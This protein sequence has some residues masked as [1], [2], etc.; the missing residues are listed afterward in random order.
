MKSLSYRAR[1]LINFSLIFICF[2]LILLG[3]QYYREIESRKALLEARL[4]SYADII[5]L[6]NQHEPIVQASKTLQQLRAVFPQDLRITIISKEG[7]VNYESNKEDLPNISN[8][9]ERPEVKDALNKGFGIDIRE[10]ETL[11]KPYFYYAKA[12]PNFI[13]RVAL[14]YNAEI[15]NFM[16]VSNIFL[17]F[18]L[19]IFPIVIVALIYISGR[20]GRAIAGLHHF[21]DSA[22]R[23]LMDYDNIS[24]PHNELGD[25][26]SK[27]LKMYQELEQ[28]TQQVGLERERLMKHFHHFE[29]GIAIFSTQ[30]QKVYSNPRFLQYLNTI[31]DITTSSV[32]AIW[33]DEK[34]KS[35]Q[36][37][38]NQQQNQNIWNAETSAYRDTLSVGSSHFAVQVVVYSDRSFEIT[39]S[40][41][42]KTEKNKL[43]KQQMSHNIS[44]ELR[45]PVSSIRGF[46]ETLITCENLSVERRKDFLQ[47]ALLQVV[48]LS[49]LIRDVALIS[50]I[51]EAAATLPRE[52][53][54]LK[55][56]VGE[57]IEELQS[58]LDKQEM[59]VLVDISENTTIYGNYSLLHSIFRNLLENS[60]RYAGQKTKVEISCYKKNADFLFFRYFNNG[61]Q[62]PEEHLPRLFE[63]FYRI[64]EGRTRD[65]GGTGLGL[66]IVKNAVGFH[67]GDI[68]V[69]NL[70]DQG[71]EFYFTLKRHK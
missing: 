9:K 4:E 44:H 24:F 45:T 41:I 25:I 50:K 47:R 3:F 70:L 63:R 53:V 46:L 15:K 2:A 49:D 58:E 26:A 18:T 16:H 1:L 12:Y 10:S 66:S 59:T 21:I 20:F 48:R 6:Q 19:L 52:N 7:K 27:V 51:E 38:L 36:D 37:F 67:S 54:D 11:Q 8:H 64:T 22:E 69:K 56:L 28:K 40:D 14:P 32:N 17:W 5:E 65:C 34:F 30:R 43:L 13:I 62:I 68:I 35:N 60:I 71:V 23:G 39:L 57:T 33:T 29:E 61:E 55:L 31:L 42:T